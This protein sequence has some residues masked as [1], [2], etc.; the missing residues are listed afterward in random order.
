MNLE[1]HL[2]SDVWSFG[3][4]LWEAF[5]FGREPYPDMDEYTVLAKAS[6]QSFNMTN[7]YKHV[8]LYGIMKVLFLDDFT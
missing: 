7:A 3:I 6:L 4:L 1:R 2:H 8:T 5:S